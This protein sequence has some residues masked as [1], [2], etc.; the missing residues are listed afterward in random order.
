MENKLV[1][2]GDAIQALKD[3]KTIY[4]QIWNGTKLVLMPAYGNINAHIAAHLW[5]NQISTWVPTHDDI[6]NDDWIIE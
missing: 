1:T 2:F 4:R 3:G 6:L 5:N